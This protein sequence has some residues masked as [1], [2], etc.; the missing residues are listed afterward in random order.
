MGFV[1]WP[2][3]RNASNPISKSRPML[4][5]LCLLLA[6]ALFAVCYASVSFFE[7]I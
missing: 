1:N 5:A 3:G 4:T 6:A 7:K 2:Q